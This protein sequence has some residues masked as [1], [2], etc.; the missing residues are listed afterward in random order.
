MTK[1]IVRADDFGMTESTSLGVLKAYHDGIVTSTSVMVNMP[2]SE[3]APQL[4]KNC[5]SLCIGLHVN[6]VIGKPISDCGKIPS[7]VDQK[8]EFISSKARREMM[9]QGKEPLPDKEDNYLE[10]EAQINRFYDLF[11]YYPEYLDTHAIQSVCLDQ[12][13]E[14][15]AEKYHCV[16]LGYYGGQ[17]RNVSNTPN[18]LKDIYRHYYDHD[19]QL[20]IVSC[21][22]DITDQELVMIVLHPGYLNEYIFTHSSLIRE[23]VKDIVALTSPETKR[24]IHENNIQ[25]ISHRDLKIAG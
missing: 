10:V 3:Q 22:K 21:E 19:P 4:L 9:A 13:L 7:L 2:G 12:V 1:L 25:L 11:G 15:L 5:P 16:F 6:L 20:L 17:S 8:G 23:R 14:A 24:W 18:K